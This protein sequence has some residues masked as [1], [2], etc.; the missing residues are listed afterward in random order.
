VLI[1]WILSRRRERASFPPFINVGLKILGKGQ[2]DTWALLEFA[3][4][5]ATRWNSTV[6]RVMRHEFPGYEVWVRLCVFA[7]LILGAAHRAVGVERTLIIDAPDSVSASEEIRAIISASTDAGV[8]EQVGFLQVEVSNDNGTTWEAICYL[9]NS[10]PEIRQAV[11]LKPRHIGTVTI[12]R[13]RAAFRDGLAGDVDYRG[14][15]IMW[16][17]NWKSWDTPPAK[18]ATIAV[19]KP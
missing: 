13:A 5:L 18:T 12:L 9:Q 2:S 16:E 1:A 7:L 14:A 19:N 17:R 15:A 3:S 4:T 10:G 8:G 11:T 6:I